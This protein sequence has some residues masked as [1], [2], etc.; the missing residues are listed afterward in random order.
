MI[1]ARHSDDNSK[2]KILVGKLRWDA[3]YRDIHPFPATLRI[4]CSSRCIINLSASYSS[5][6]SNFPEASPKT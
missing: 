1:G 4:I 3:E 6:R 5:C 2:N